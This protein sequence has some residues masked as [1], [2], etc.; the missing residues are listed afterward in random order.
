M[1][2]QGEIQQN[3]EHLKLLAI[4][5]YVRAGL[6]LL[7]FVIGT[8]AMIFMKATISQEMASKEA[9]IFSMV[10][11]FGYG[12]FVALFVIAPG[13]MTAISGHFISKRKNYMFVFIWA[14][15]QCLSFPFGTALGVCTIIVL[16]RPAV[17]D[18]FAKGKIT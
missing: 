15:F 9:Q 16:Q 12:I 3:A 8:A 7:S 6:T 1:T 13:I 2:D 11:M 14:C 17:K 10:I 18:E 5:H 4:F